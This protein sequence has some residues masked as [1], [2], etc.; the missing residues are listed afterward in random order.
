[1]SFNYN[2]GN[3]S[4][5]PY[6]DH[7]TT[8]APGEQCP[9]DSVIETLETCKNAISQLEKT[10]KK[11]QSG[12]RYPAGCYYFHSKGYFNNVVD[13]AKIVNPLTTYGAI[14]LIAGILT[15]NCYYFTFNHR[16]I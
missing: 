1:M 8:T 16:D 3:N 14:C 11:V 15:L 12:T 5:I 4:Y 9:Q 13:Q 7:Y 10:W 2:V 6:T